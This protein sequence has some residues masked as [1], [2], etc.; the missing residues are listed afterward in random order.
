M[1]SLGLRGRLTLALA[2]LMAVTVFLMTLVV[3]PLFERQVV[4]DHAAQAG[5]VTRA[6]AA[7]L[8]H[9]K[10]S[11]EFARRQMPSKRHGLR[12]SNRVAMRRSR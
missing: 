6:V 8:A 1:R 11:D 2:L 3:P 10:D 12:D 7:G 5:L 4:R 9:V